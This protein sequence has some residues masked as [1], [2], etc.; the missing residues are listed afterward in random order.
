MLKASLILAASIVFALGRS[1][2]AAEPKLEATFDIGGNP[3]I[4]L[5]FSPDGKHLAVAALTVPARPK[6]DPKQS[7]Y[8][9]I[10]RSVWMIASGS[11][12]TD[13]TPRGTLKLWNIDKKQAILS[14]DIDSETAAHFAFSADGESFALR[15]GRDVHR[16]NLAASGP[17]KLPTLTSPPDA[18]YDADD[19]VLFSPDGKRVFIPGKP[20]RIWNLTDPPTT[21]A[22]TVKG[23]EGQ[24]LAFS[25]NG[26]FLA[27]TSH[28]LTEEF[29]PL[30][31]IILFD[32]A[33]LK[34]IRTVV[35][36]LEGIVVEVKFSPDGRALYF[37]VI[38]DVKLPK[39]EWREVDLATGAT[40]AR[41]PGKSADV[42]EISSDDV[43]NVT[44]RRTDERA[45]AVTFRAHEKR[46]VQ[47]AQSR[48][49]KRLAT[50]AAEVKVWRVD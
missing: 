43:G 5:E 1:A 39:L 42:L 49:G 35:E 2:A 22:V 26:K 10:A 9:G 36:K 11:A 32:A 50:G 34:P 20:W 47:F 48:D 17:R 23:V 6:L 24:S 14:F 27:A 46:A 19:P 18:S 33:T 21:Q 29:K 4:L 30:A 37:A 40:R 44:F 7:I 25:A 15:S 28:E 16:W 12:F 3:V 31:K 38:T 13:T 45:A 8:E 41:G